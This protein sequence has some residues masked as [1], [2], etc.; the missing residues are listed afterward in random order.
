MSGHV[1]M[2]PMGETVVV[3][4]AQSSDHA[5]AQH[6]AAEELNRHRRGTS[7]HRQSNYSRDHR[8][9]SRSR[10]RTG[11][12]KTGERKE[13]QE[14]VN[15]DEVAEAAPKTPFMTYT[16]SFV[17]VL[18]VLLQILGTPWLPGGLAK[19]G[20]GITETRETV[21]LF[22]GS[23]ATLTIQNSANPFYGPDVSDIIKWGA[24]YAPCMRSS[25]AT[26]TYESI[27]AGESRAGCCI[28]NGQCGVLNQTDCNSFNGMFQGEGSRCNGSCTLTLRPCCYGATYQ[29]LV[30]TQSYCNALDGVYHDDDSS[31]QTC[32][33][34]NCLNDICGLGADAEP[35]KPP[36]QAERLF[37]PIFLHAG[38]IHLIFNILIQIS[39]G[40]EIEQASSWW[41]FSI[42]YIGSG[43]GGFSFAA[44]FVPD[45]VSVGA[46][47]SIYGLLG[48]DFVHLLHRWKALRDRWSAL[49]CA[50]FS[51]F[52]YLV[53]GTLP[54]IDNWAH[55]GGFF[56]GLLFGN[57][58]LP[59]YEWAGWKRH[60]GFIFSAAL[61]GISFIVLLTLFYENTDPEFC[62]W[63]KF[64]NCIEYTPGLCDDEFG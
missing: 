43:I 59:F 49:S 45:Q 60:L 47:A 5:L 53:F 33:D 38:V 3:S 29:C 10:S 26:D 21:R 18:I 62:S 48:V 13:D 17:Q 22:D 40:K 28:L 2:L 8:A 14:W 24:K 41:R 31:T 51:A 37:L 4:A 23:E 61:I 44:L 58:F 9:T 52:L 1:E 7:R 20:L 36:R 12:G 15:E 30:Q 35:G 57:V 64:I 27:A 11:R 42:M 34:V 46:S 19:W 16:F 6:L 39:L 54:W 50:I 55:S 56:F 63:C 32:G 25:I